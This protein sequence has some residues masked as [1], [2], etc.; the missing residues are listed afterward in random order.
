[1]KFYEDDI[2]SKSYLL[3][4]LSNKDVIENMKS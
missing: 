4:F 3:I 1:M 2:I